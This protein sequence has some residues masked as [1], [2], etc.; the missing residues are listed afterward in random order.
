MR[1]PGRWVAREL[2][3]SHGLFGAPLEPRSGAT[4][5]FAA[6]AERR[7]GGGASSLSGTSDHQISRSYVCELADLLQIFLL[8]YTD[9]HD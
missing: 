4:S 2:P 3:A 5:A 1:L 9:D 6:H 8:S 7:T